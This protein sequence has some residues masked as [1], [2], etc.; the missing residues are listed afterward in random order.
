MGLG[1]RNHGKRG[2]KQRRGVPG[3]LTGYKRVGAR[4]KGGCSMIS[5]VGRL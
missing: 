5:E 2:H 3:W 1:K 4:E